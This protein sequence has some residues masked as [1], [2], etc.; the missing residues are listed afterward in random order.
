KENVQAIPTGRLN[1]VKNNEVLNY[2]EKV[3][4]TESRIN[5]ELWQ[6]DI[7]HLS[8]GQNPSEIRSLRSILG[9]VAPNVGNSFL[10]GKVTAFSKQTNL[11]IEPID[12][13]KQVNAG[14]G[15]ITFTGHGSANEIDLNIGYCSPPQNGF[16]NKGKYPVMFFNGCGVG[17]IFYRYNALSTDWLLTPDKGAIVVFA[18]SFWSYAYPTQ[19]YL[20]VL[21]EKLFVDSATVNLTI[22][23]IQQAT[24]I[25]LSAEDGNDYIKA[26]IHQVILQGDP[27]LQLFPIQKPDYQVTERSVFIKSVN[28]SRP[29]AENDSLNVGII[30]QNNG[31]F[32]NGKPVTVS[33]KQLLLNNTERLKTATINAV[34]Y[35]D[36]V[37]VKIKKDA[38]VKQ[39]TVVID[40]ENNTDEYNESN[41]EAILKLENWDEINTRTSFPDNILPDLLPPVLQVLIDNKLIANNGFVAK[42][43]TINLELTDNEPL[44]S[45]SNYHF[46]VLLKSCESCEYERVNLT[47]QRNEA[48]LSTKFSINLP[49]QNLQ[50]GIYNLR[51]NAKDFAGNSLVKP[52]EIQFNVAEK[53]LPSTLTIFP[54]PGNDFVQIRYVIVAFSEPTAAKIVVYNASGKQMFEEKQQPKIGENNYF[55]D[56]KTFAAGRYFAKVI[57]NG[58]EIISAPFIVE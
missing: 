43:P 19:R 12:I 37:Y 42:S 15:M 50:A 21:Y 24:N 34:A 49:L 23:Q 20:D 28:E 9:N 25:Q 3:K 41:N 40:G 13:S 52:N 58:T 29:I 46:D 54:N 44:D 17:N 55:V 30:M 27:A 38:T 56:T 47:Q 18:N 39:L 33:V 31:R 7:L 51:I 14:L 11:E 4:E 16:S 10:G 1:V 45:V 6:K 8:G 35:Q 32:V 22:G 26:N 36:T 48:T 57:I 5:P 53:E 2:L